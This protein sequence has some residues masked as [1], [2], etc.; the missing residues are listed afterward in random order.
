MTHKFLHIDNVRRMGQYYS[1]D[2]GRKIYSPN[3]NRQIYVIV[4]DYDEDPKAVNNTIKNIGYANHKASSLGIDF[5]I[6]G[7]ILAD[8]SGP[9]TVKANKGAL[10]TAKDWLERESGKDRPIPDIYHLEIGEKTDEILGDYVSEFFGDII[11][12]GPEP[13]GKGWNMLL[14]SLA[15]GRYPDDEVG[16]IYMDAE[17]EEIGPSQLI[18]MG[19]PMF[20]KD[21]SMKFIKAAFD[22]Y[23]M[24]DGKR[25]LGGRVNASAFKPMINMLSAHGMMPKI[26]Y[27]LSG[28]IT[29]RRDV[30]WD[31][32]FARRFGVEWATLIQLLSPTSENALDVENEFAEV[33]LGLN[34]DQPLGE[35]RSPEEILEKVGEMTD[36]IMKANNSLLDDEIRKEWDTHEDFINEFKKNQSEH[37]RKWSRE[38]RKGEKAVEITG[39]ITLDE[40]KEKSL[41]G[42]YD[43]IKRLYSGETFDGELLVSM[44]SIRNSIGESEF[45][46]FLGS[47]MDIRKNIKD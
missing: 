34:M 5:W 32:R 43:N 30:L 47:F 7:I 15:T 21:S 16:I 13:R 17:N 41:E 20:Y 3:S 6:N 11:S 29:I 8:Q 14:S 2:T 31:I 42:V 12:S 22:R 18:A 4:P 45:D 46:E 33:Y 39:G 19:L 9:E 28:E 26:R 27:P 1:G 40:L 35:G 36:Q 23:H 25:K 37:C 38:Y 24:E 10:Y 44:N